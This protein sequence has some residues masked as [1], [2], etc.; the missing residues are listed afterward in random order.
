MKPDVRSVLFLFSLTT[1]LVVLA[2][3]VSAQELSGRWIMDL[4]VE[5]PEEATACIYSGNCQ[6][7]QDGSSLSGTLILALVSG[8]KECPPEVSGNIEGTVEGDSV[9]GS[10]IGGELG[11]ASFQGSRSND[12]YSGTFEASPDG[13][14]AGTGGSW[15]AVPPDPDL[16]LIKAG[17]F[18]DESGDGFAQAG[19]TISYSFNVTNTGNQTL[20][21]VAVSDPLVSTITCPGGNPIPSLEPEA[22]ETCAG[23]YT[24]TQADVQVGSRDNTATVE[25]EDP[26]G[27]FVSTSHATS[28]TL[29]EVPVPPI[30]VPTLSQWGLFFLALV[31]SILVA[32]RLY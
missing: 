12:S 13:P 25:G 10:F 24:V 30:G 20:S 26:D 14:F 7:Q 23:D 16:E 17:T 6:L 21:S 22:T 29:T 28:T 4:T 19:E 31:L 5:L 27:D 11:T 18:E 3:Q 8:P 9:F 32:R 2:P 1:I 15:L